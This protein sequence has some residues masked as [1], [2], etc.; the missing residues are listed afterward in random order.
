MVTADFLDYQQAATSLFSKI[1]NTKI[2][3]IVYNKNT[4]LKVNFRTSFKEDFKC[5]RIGYV[6]STKKQK[7]TE[8][9]QLPK[10][11]ALKI[12]QFSLSKNKKRDFT[13]MLKY[14]SHEVDKQYYELILKTKKPIK[15]KQ[16]KKKKKIAN[17]TL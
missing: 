3:Q 14:I 2:K 15:Q 6:R 12:E 7:S 1:P 13:K 16:K 11:M 10:V 17:K 5:V 4:I 9:L 8:L